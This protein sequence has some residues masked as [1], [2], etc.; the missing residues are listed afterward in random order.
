M[1]ARKKDGGGA[2]TEGADST[3]G[4]EAAGGEAAGGV[5]RAEGEVELDASPERV[6]QALTEAAELERWF[7]LHARVDPGEGGTVWMSWGHEYAA[8]MTIDAWDPP[9]HLRTTWGFEGEAGQATDYWLEAR[10]GRTYLRVV[11]SGFPADASWDD[12]VEGTR[13]GWLFE[14]AS[15]KHYL[16]RH[17][18]ERR[19]ATYIRRRVTLSREEAWSRLVGEDG[20]VL[21]E[22]SDE[23]VDRS[24]PWQFAGIV[25][26]PPDGLIRLTI[27]PTHSDPDRRDV[28][29]WLS[30]W[31]DGASAVEDCARAWSRRL[32]RLFPEGQPL[33]A[34]VI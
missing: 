17:D 32:T 33:E 5:R 18:G 10:G 22:L 34:E 7:A 31:G 16:E 20:V 28:T 25:D 29:V 12:L 14:L 4:A 21:E 3:A 27:D 23:V 2:A 19:A 30:G 24:P 11:T 15:L 13:L 6:W 9:R 8:S 26:D 1:M